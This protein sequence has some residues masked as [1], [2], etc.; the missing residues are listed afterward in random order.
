MGEKQNSY[1]IGLMHPFNGCEESGTVVE[2]KVRAAKESDVSSIVVADAFWG[3]V[4][5]CDECKT[6]LV[7]ADQRLGCLVVEQAEV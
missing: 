1:G 6:G 4:P 7:L 3:Q 2:V 5:R